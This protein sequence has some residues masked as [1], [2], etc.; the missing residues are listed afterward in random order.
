M[1]ADVPLEAGMSFSALR[2]DRRWVGWRWEK[3]KRTGRR[4]KLLYSPGSGRLAKSND[5]ST[6]ASWDAAHAMEGTDGVAY[7]LFGRT[8]LAAL[9]ED[10]CRDA[11]SG[12]LLPWRMP[13][14]S[15]APAIAKSRRAGP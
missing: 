3:D 8:N 2:Q 13:T 4:V 15:A 11:Q 5:A 10:H 9:D 7:S 12:A 1:T 14:L 6:W